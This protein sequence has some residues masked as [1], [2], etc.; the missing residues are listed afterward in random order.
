MQPCS[1]EYNNGE[2]TPGNYCI[3][4]K[5]ANGCL[6]AQACFEVTNPPMLDV[7]VTALDVTCDAPGSIVLEIN[8]GTPNAD[9]NYSIIWLDDPASQSQP[10]VDNPG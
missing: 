3:I 2:L 9:G 5:D 8:G 1:N 7:D 6:A 10:P 4:V